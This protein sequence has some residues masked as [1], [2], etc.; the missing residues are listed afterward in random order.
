MLELAGD[1]VEKSDN[2]V[3]EQGHDCDDRSSDKGTDDRVFDCCG[4][5]LV[6]GVDTP[7]VEVRA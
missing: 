4:S 2:F 7:S 3:A 6:M 5:G 1:C